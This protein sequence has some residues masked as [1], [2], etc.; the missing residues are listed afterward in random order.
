[1]PCGER[2]T[3]TPRN[4]CRAVIIGLAALLATGAAVSPFRQAPLRADADRFRAKVDAI[5]RFAEKPASK[6]LV[7]RIT[8]SE[9]NAYLA[10]D[11][12][13]HLPAGL[14]E[15][16]ITVLPSL[17][18]SGTALVDLDAVRK[19]RQS[20]GWLDPLSYLSGTLAVAIVGR[21]EATQGQARFAL[22][23]ASVGG[24]TVPKVIV[25]ELVS[26]FS[27][28]DANPRGINIDDPIPAARP[29][30]R[31]RHPAG[32]GVRQAVRT[33][34]TRP[35]S[36]DPLR[37][38]KGVGPQRERALASAGLNTVGDL[39]ARLPFR[40]EDRTAFRPVADLHEG[41]T[42]TVAGELINCRLRWTGRRGFKIFEA[43][44]RDESGCL[45]AVWPNQ[46]FRQ[47]TLR[48]HQ[49]A[50]L[51]GPV[52]RFRNVL[53]MSNPDVEIVD[54]AEAE[55]LHTRRIVPVYERIG[56]VTSRM[57]RTMV[58]GVVEAMPTDGEDL[59]PRA[60]RDRHRYPDRQR[61]LADAHFPP[62]GTEAA[63]LA[64]FRTPAA[65]APD[66]RGVLPVSVRGA[67]ASPRCRSGTQAAACRWWTIA[68]AIRRRRAAAVPTDTGTARGAPRDR[69]GHAAAQPDEP[70]AAG[71][72]RLRQDRRGADRRP[73]RSRERPPGGGD[74]ADRDPGGAARRDRGAF[75]G[76]DAVRRRPADRLDAG[77]RAAGAAGRTRDRPRPAR[78]RH[79]RAD[80]GGRGLR[81]SRSGHRGR[82]APVRRHAA[83]AAAREGTPPG[84][85]GDDRHADS[86]H[87]A[88]HALRRA[89]R[90]G[91]PGHAARPGAGEDD[92]ET[93][94][95]A[96]RGVRVRRG[97]GGARAAGVRGLPARRRVGEGRPARGD[98]DGR[99]PGARRVPARIASGSC[100]A[101]WRRR[102]RTT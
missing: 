28:T 34:T 1:M 74:G 69:R 82:A 99:P 33:W 19:Q 35:S 89:R 7:T 98:R 44:V 24:V 75:P 18:L 27:K 60:L 21:L 37:T 10:Y 77:D 22:Q 5:T 62:A 12:T 23:S 48:P 51:H 71:R 54:D 65:A 2:V 101:G 85:P 9:L 94:G 79:P 13:P 45:L 95:A 83:R 80:R 55:P 29:D 11:A 81:A 97:A 93:G 25:Q 76:G 56:P 8:E 59:L 90:V 31:D 58:H 67:G 53:Q 70:A 87:A 88:A 78:G 73:G 57:L 61:A 100:T 4:H 96:R 17:D 30:P 84:H 49:R 46:A 38:V 16:R 42:A 3:K 72:R 47:T 66:L 64:A 86:A 36:I 14:T 68:I 52:T 92:R 26:F 39:L 102:R 32:R 20:R 63:R 6:P 15:P 91:D 50:V 43:A 40:Y 41:E